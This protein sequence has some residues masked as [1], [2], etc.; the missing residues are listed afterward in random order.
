MTPGRQICMA[1]PISNHSHP[2]I[3]HLT[4]HSST[5]V[6]AGSCG[7][8]ASCFATSNARVTPPNSS[9]RPIW[10]SKRQVKSSS[11][12]HGH[13]EGTRCAGGRLCP[14]GV[15]R[16]VESSSMTRE[17][18][19]LGQGTDTVAETMQ[20]RQTQALTFEATELCKG[21]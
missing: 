3:T 12:N 18:M 16:C 6:S 8:P 21:I 15:V 5:C 17:K 7:N 1:R 11:S 13:G 19:V 10:S 4:G 9:T 20:Q 14:V 2:N